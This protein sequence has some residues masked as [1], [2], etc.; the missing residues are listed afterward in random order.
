[1]SYAPVDYAELKARYTKQKYILRQLEDENKLLGAQLKAY[2]KG[3][4]DLSGATSFAVE[5]DGTKLGTIS[6][7][8]AQP[9]TKL[10]ITDQEAFYSWAAKNGYLSYEPRVDESAIEDCM[11]TG[12][13]PDGCVVEQTQGGFS[14]IVCRPDK[15]VL[16][17]M[18]EAGKLG[19]V[20]QLI[21]GKENE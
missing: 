16:K 1:M 6:V 15:K 12:E 7:V 10:R 9:T 4:Y 19:G 18:F 13:I 8:T 21:E 2:C 14:H 5:E 20:K 17:P 11:E 3:L